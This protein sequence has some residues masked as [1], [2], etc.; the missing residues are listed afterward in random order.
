MCR[1]N[2]RQ[3][4]LELGNLQLSKNDDNLLLY[5][6][7]E[8]IKIVTEDDLWTDL[9]PHGSNDPLHVFIPAGVKCA[10]SAFV[11][12]LKDFT[13]SSLSRL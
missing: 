3:S 8:Q 2:G 9:H 10:T 4:F 1:Q 12:D 13:R 7:R 11:C 6:V 5:S